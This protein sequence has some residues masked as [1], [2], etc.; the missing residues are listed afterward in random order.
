L[1][2][3]IQSITLAPRKAMRV[4]NQD[5]R[6]ISVQA[7]AGTYVVLLGMS[8]DK[9]L[10]DGLLGF[11]IERVDHT[12]GERRFLENPL[13]FEAND[14]GNAPDHSTRRNPVQEFVWGDYAAKPNHTY[15][16]TV[17]AMRGTPARLRA[18]AS[19]QVTVST[20]DPDDGTHGVWF[21][22]GVAASAAYVDRF[23][24][25]K[26]A[27]VPNREAYK[28]LG[29][30]LEEA[31]TT[32]IGQATDDRFGLRAGMYEF[33]W[34]PVLDAFKVAAD[35][36]ADVRIV[37]HAVPKSGDKTPAQNLAAIKKAKL[38][39]IS[40]ARTNT[41]IA[42][43]KFVVLLEKGKPVAVWSGS[44]NVTEGGIFGHAN[45]GH[46]IRDG[47]IAR[48][49]LDYWEQLKDDP[50]SAKLKAFDDPPPKVPPKRPQAKQTTLFSPRTQ[51]DSLDWYVRLA[52]DANQAIFLT[53]AFGLTAE[54]APVFAGQKDYLRYLL[55]D[56]RDGKIE[57][58]RREPSNIVAAGGLKAKGGFRTWIAAELQRINTFV[59]YIHTKFMLIDPLTDDPIVITGSANWSDESVK[60][61]DEN[62]VVIRGDKRVA[63]IYLTEFMRLFNHY[64]LRGRAKTPRTTIEPAPGVPE[65][66][67][68]KLHLKPDDSWAKP[69]Y[70]ANSPEEKERLLF[71]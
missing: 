42:H 4:R 36:G 38:F 40:K 55:M 8:V 2:S 35:A 6:K 31:L 41:T 52:A 63:D 69:F 70:V 30:G 64:R 62:M 11:T 28:W 47:R 56:L 66:Q 10:F 19:V 16:Y 3:L 37:Y 14:V 13:L 71:Q 20:E 27:D 68:G 17:T 12:E 23:G 46:A 49:Y 9:S 59:D 21:N 53:A 1:R 7:I 18:A 61:N 60:R 57:A 67:R 22:R 48:A 45:V 5:D 65:A 24:N 51:L 43:N 54:I 32:F 26:P 33:K 15:S 50:A 44:T 29:R 34:S 39:D 58:M 25:V